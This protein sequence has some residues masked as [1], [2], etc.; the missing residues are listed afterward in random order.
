[1][2]SR[3]DDRPPTPDDA[4]LEYA[5]LGRSFV[6]RGR[7]IAGQVRLMRRLSTEQ[8]ATHEDVMSV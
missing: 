2:G 3:D 6:D 8:S 4:A 5:A 1:M 7:R